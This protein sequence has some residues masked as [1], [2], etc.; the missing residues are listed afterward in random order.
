MSCAGGTM[1]TERS[2]LLSFHEALKMVLEHAAPRPGESVSLDRLVGRML[3]EPIT[4]SHDLPAF[5]N[6]AVD[7]Y[8]FH[9][10]DV[11]EGVRFRSF[12]ILGESRAGSSACPTV[13]PGGAVRVFTGAPLP[14]A[15]GA[16]AM[17]EVCALDDGHVR[18]DEPLELEDNIRRRGCEARAGDIVVPATVVT[19]PAV[20]AIATCGRP[21]AMVVGKPSVAVLVTGD[22]LACP[23]SALGSGQVFESNGVGLAAAL[24]GLGLDRIT[25]AR[26]K[27]DPHETE[28]TARKLLADH[29]ILVTSGGVSVGAHDMVRPALGRIGVKEVF[30]GVAIKPGKPIYFGVNDGKAVFGLPGN[31][32]SALVTFALFVRPFLM[33]QMGRSGDHRVERF[34]LATPL[35]KRVGRAEFVPCDIAEGRA[36]PAVGRA[37]HKASCLASAQGLAY[38]GPDVEHAEAGSLVD[39]YPLRWGWES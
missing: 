2:K 20:A 22:E 14:E 35:A 15:V 33:R 30:W 32:V 34:A 28:R 26:C 31:P 11:R 25:V 38:L 12:R 13:V 3:S 4:A 39:V 1:V 21:S 19:P 7:G 10:D 24:E 23:G 29:D 5:D 36:I 17:Q 37:S 27:D 9:E 18:V 6:S 16:V 8:A